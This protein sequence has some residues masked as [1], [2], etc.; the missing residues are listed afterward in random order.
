MSWRQKFVPGNFQTGVPTVYVLTRIYWTNLKKYQGQ[1]DQAC[2]LVQRQRREKKGSISSTPES[3]QSLR[4]S[5]E[6]LDIARRR[7]SSSTG[8]THRPSL[9]S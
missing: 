7:D 9:E 5:C 4:L 2:V 8:R 1:N 6:E 3:D